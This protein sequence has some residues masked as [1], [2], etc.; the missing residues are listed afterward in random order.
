[1]GSETFNLIPQHVPKDVHAGGKPHAQLSAKLS[2]EVD[3]YKRQRGDDDVGLLGGA[4]E[5]ASSLAYHGS[6]SWLKGGFQLFDDAANGL[7]IYKQLGIEGATPAADG[8]SAA[9]NAIGITKPEEAAFGSG[10]WYW[11]QAG[12]AFGYA[13]PFIITHYA[14]HSLGLSGVARAERTVALSSNGKL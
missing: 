1:M 5:F 11:Q 12:G 2:R 14:R 3:D 7:G 10:R 6:A 8:V 4:A 9:F 13:V